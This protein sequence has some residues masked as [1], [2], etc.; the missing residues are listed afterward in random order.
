MLFEHHNLRT[1]GTS[2]PPRWADRAPHDSDSTRASESPCSST[3][4]RWRGA[5]MASPNLAQSSHRRLYT[6]DEYALATACDM[7]IPSFRRCRGY[8]WPDGWLASPLIHR[9]R[10][11]AD[12]HPGHPR[13]GRRGTTCRSR[14]TLPAPRR[15]SRFVRWTRRAGACRTEGGDFLGCN[16]SRLPLGAAGR[17]CYASRPGCPPERPR[18]RPGWSSTVC[19][20]I[21]DVCA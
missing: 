5:M 8:L 3:Y 13:D 2:V 20:M 7:S 12:V 17:N 9:E 16:R 19:P 14:M 4:T 11:R 18:C 6:L 15:P 10:A 1:S 21:C